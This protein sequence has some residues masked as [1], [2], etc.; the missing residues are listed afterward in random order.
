MELITV[1]MRSPR[2]YGE[3]F[4]LWFTP[5]GHSLLVLTGSS[6]GPNRLHRW[7]L[8][9]GKLTGRRTV[10]TDDEHGICHPEPTFTRDHRLMAYGDRF[11]E[12]RTRRQKYLVGAHDNYY[13]GFAFA[14]DGAVL[15]GAVSGRRAD[16][17]W[18][19]DRWDLPIKIAGSGDHIQAWPEVSLSITDDDFGGPSEL[20]VSPDGGLLAVQMYDAR[21]VYRFKLP[22]GELMH[23]LTLPGVHGQG[24]GDGTLRFSPDGRTLAVAAPGVYLLDPL[25]TSRPRLTLPTG[26]VAD[27]AFTP[28]GT[29]LLTVAGKEATVWD[30]AA[31]KPLARYGWGK[32]AGPLRA[33]AVAPDGLTAAVGGTRGRVVRW[34]LDD[35]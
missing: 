23:P 9:A 3:V 29:R 12:V 18:W 22:T 28:D 6:D 13:A 1:P 15:Y 5:S 8:V 2:F 7:N 30:T 21:R 10:V 19:I 27:L 35:G 20:A 26:P 14:S 24:E 17:L 31:G 11:E 34:D 32:Q 4:R 33:V 25:G 16:Q